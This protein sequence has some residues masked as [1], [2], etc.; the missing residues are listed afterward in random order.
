MAQSA[1]SLVLGIWQNKPTETGPTTG[2]LNSDCQASNKLATCSDAIVEK[3]AT[4]A[5]KK[6]LGDN[7]H[8]TLLC[9]ED[10]WDDDLR[11]QSSRV[12][13]G[14]S[15]IVALEGWDLGS[16]PTEFLKAEKN[17][18]PDP[19]VWGRLK[20]FILK[21]VSHRLLPKWEVFTEIAVSLQPWKIF[22]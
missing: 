21:V 1:L 20:Y 14:S 2:T 16:L 19:K 17:L 5:E 13:E 22:S 15:L 12:E 6:P 8:V 4:L 18:C 3:T 10:T 9:E 7:T 11:V